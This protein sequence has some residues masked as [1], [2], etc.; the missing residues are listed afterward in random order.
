MRGEGKLAVLAVTTLNMDFGFIIFTR[1]KMLKRK[2]TL[3]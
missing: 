1:G 2:S 3:K